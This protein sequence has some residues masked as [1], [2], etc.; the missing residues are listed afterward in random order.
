MKIYLIHY[1]E[2]NGIYGRDRTR[3]EEDQHGALQFIAD[4]A[5]GHHED[6]KIKSVYEADLNRGV[7]HEVEPKLEGFKLSLVR[8]PKEGR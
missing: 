6:T 7:M 1:L 8:I 2:G 4:V 3:T 5:T